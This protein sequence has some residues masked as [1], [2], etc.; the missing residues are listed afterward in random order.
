M[1]IS[2]FQSS[3]ILSNSSDNNLNIKENFESKSELKQACK[4]FEALF[5]HKM[6]QSMRKT[7]PES[8]LL[9]GGLAEE[10]YTD[11]LDQQVA[12]AAAEKDSFGIGAIVYDEMV[13]NIDSGT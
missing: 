7:V 13:K 10:I 4:D 8:G 2:L 11:M 6:L 5:I 12:S 9:D 1:S 3:V